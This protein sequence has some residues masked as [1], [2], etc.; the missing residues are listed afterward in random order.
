MGLE[1]EIWKGEGEGGSMAGQ[2]NV[3]SKQCVPA[4]LFVKVRINHEREGKTWD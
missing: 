1:D 2:I 4:R 3:K